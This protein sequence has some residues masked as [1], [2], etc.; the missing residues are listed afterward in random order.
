MLDIM[1]LLDTTHL[2]DIRQEFIEAEDGLELTHFVR[3]MLKYLSK[4]QVDEQHLV[5]SL[6]EL[7]AQ[8]DVNGDATMEWDEF[9]GYIHEQGMAGTDD[10]SSMMKYNSRSVFEDR[11]LPKRSDTV[12]HYKGTDWIGITAYNS[13]NLILYDIV[14]RKQV[15][16]LE[17]KAAVLASTYIDHRGKK[18]L[19][20]S[21]CDYHMTV[22]DTQSVWEASGFAEVLPP[23][24]APESQTVLVWDADTSTLFSGGVNGAVNTWDITTHE[25]KSMKL[26]GHKSAVRAILFVPSLNAIITGSLD[27]TMILWES[28]GGKKRKIYRGHR[29]GI[30]AVAYSTDTKLIVSAGVAD[31]I[32]VH[33]RPPSPGAPTDAPTSKRRLLLLRSK[34]PDHVKSALLQVWNPFVERRIAE[35]SGHK[36][37]LLGLHVVESRTG[38]YEVLSADRSGIFK[39]WDLRSF[40][41]IQTFSVAAALG[42]VRQYINLQ[43]KNQIVAAF[44]RK[45]QAF[46]FSYTNTPELTDDH[47]VIGALYNETLD[48]FITA[49]GC[50]VR[51]WDS[52]TGSF[53]SRD[54]LCA[55]TALVM[56][57]TDCREASR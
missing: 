26:Q 47:E 32:L 7:F 52:M 18:M 34:P 33:P 19:V 29:N 13:V 5:A 31:E 15:H 30:Q 35:L 38:S 9:Y 41:C 8:V 21:T 10:T 40:E 20:V 57:R 53:R 36:A 45:F 16:E 49:A 42:G 39:V 48:S 54:A 51:I 46:E 22:W 55:A 27:G 28:V 37:T 6:C 4:E 17:H 3:V 43:H 44:D 23:M 14:A 24:M 2:S 25:A 1:M 56:Q 12:T 50:S 11:S